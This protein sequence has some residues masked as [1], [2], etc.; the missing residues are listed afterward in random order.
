MLVLHAVSSSCAAARIGPW[1]PVHKTSVNAHLL[2]VSFCGHPEIVRRE[3]K[4]GGFEMAFEDLS[5]RT[6]NSASGTR[7][8]VPP[9]VARALIMAAL[10]IAVVFRAIITA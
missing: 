4:P 1:G 10:E 7:R 6:S 3:A 5:L 2:R 8:S 9:E